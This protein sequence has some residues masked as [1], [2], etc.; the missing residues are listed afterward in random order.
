MGLHV[1]SR[2]AFLS[3]YDGSLESYMDDFID[4]VAWGLNA[5]FSNGTASHPSCP[6]LLAKCP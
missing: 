3:T 5:I 6:A 4:K 2:V 1:H